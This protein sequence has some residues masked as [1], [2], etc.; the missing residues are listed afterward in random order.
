MTLDLRRTEPI[1]YR[2]PVAARGSAQ[3]SRVSAGVVE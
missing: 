3:A 1:R 2:V